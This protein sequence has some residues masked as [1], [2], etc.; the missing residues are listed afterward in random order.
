[1]WIEMWWKPA[2]SSIHRQIVVGF[3]VQSIL[4]ERHGDVARGQCDAESPHCGRGA[5]VVALHSCN[6]TLGQS[7]PFGQFALRD[8]CDGARRSQ[9]AS[10]IWRR[11]GHPSSMQSAAAAGGV[12]AESCG[13]S[14]SI[15]ESL[16]GVWPDTGEL[17]RPLGQL[18]STRVRE[19]AWQR[20][21]SH[22]SSD[23][24]TGA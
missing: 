10:N 1:M 24:S 14:G 23:L 9:E 18:P 13:R 17:P 20:G 5:N 12:T 6:R 15:S 7:R 4:G 16:G 21:R 11:H 2:A 19:V 3:E 8:V 22:P